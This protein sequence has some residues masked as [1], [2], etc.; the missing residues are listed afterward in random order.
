MSVFF[1]SIQSPGVPP[2]DSISLSFT[3]EPT[4]H[5]LGVPLLAAVLMARAPTESGQRDQLVVAA[6][7]ATHANVSSTVVPFAAKRVTASASPSPKPK[8]SKVIRTPGFSVVAGGDGEGRVRAVVVE[9]LEPADVDRRGTGVDKLD[10]IGA[11]VV[12][13]VD[14]HVGVGGPRG[15][16]DRH[17]TRG[18]Q[19]RG[20]EERQDWTTPGTMHVIPLQG[21]AAEPAVN[22]VSA[23]SCRWATCP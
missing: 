8:A 1:S 12:D 23:A 7:G 11:D 17:D 15:S 5:T 9:E 20:S 21:E 3:T 2:R 19:G 6:P 4:E 10:E 18:G 13:L 14:P 16:P 22:E